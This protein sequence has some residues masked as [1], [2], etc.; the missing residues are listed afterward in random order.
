MSPPSLV[1]RMTHLTTRTHRLAQ[2]GRI[3]TRCADHAG[4]RLHAAASALE[5]IDPAPVLA[6]L[7]RLG[8]LARR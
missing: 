3:M 8:D 6:T 2:H 5:N 1:D 4:E 7:R